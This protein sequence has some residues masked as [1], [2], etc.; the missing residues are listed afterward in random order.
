MTEIIFLCIGILGGFAA[1]WLLQKSK[2]GS[3]SAQIA[4]KEGELERE[5][6]LYHLEQERSKQRE[7]ELEQRLMQ[8]NDENKELRSARDVS[9]RK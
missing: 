3:L 6:Q 7:R 8:M 5:R 4:A 9:E 2:T 1:G